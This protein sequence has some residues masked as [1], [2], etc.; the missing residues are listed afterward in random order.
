LQRLIGFL[1]RD[2][3]VNPNQ[4]PNTAN[5]SLPASKATIASRLLLCPEYFS[6]VLHELKSA[7]LITI[8]RRE[9]RILVVQKLVAFGTEQGKAA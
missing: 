2:V 5:I 6:R 1:L 8:D 4:V 9:I 3:V 7:Q